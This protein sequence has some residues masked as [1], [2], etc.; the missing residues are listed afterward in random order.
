MSYL[1]AVRLHFAGTFRADVSTVNNYAPHFDDETFTSEE[2]L[3]GNDRGWWQ[4]AG[5]GA[6]RIEDC[7]V[8]RVCYLDGTDASDPAVEAAVGMKVME[9]N[10]R[11]SAKLVDLDV[12][13]QLVSTIYG[14]RIAVADPAGGKIL[15]SGEFEPAAFYDIFWRRALGGGGSDSGASA[16]YQ[17]V[18]RGVSWADVGHS[19][20]LTELR[21]RTADGLLSIRFMVDGYALNGPRRGY[22]RIVGT[23]GPAAADEPRHFV[24]GRHLCPPALEVNLSANTFGSV[25][26]AWSD[27]RNRFVADFGNAMPTSTPGGPAADI[28][29]VGLGI[30][31]PSGELLDLGVLNSG[32]EPWYERTAGIQ[33]FPPDREMTEEEIAVSQ[34]FPLVAFNYAVANGRLA[35]FQVKASEN[36]DGRF[37]RFDN[38]V[39][40][41][42]PG[43]SADML[44]WATR[45]GKPLPDAEIE[46][47]VSGHGLQPEG[48][49][50]TIPVADPAAAL[51]VSGARTDANGRAAVHLTAGNPLGKRKYID[52]QIYCVE[53]RIKNAAGTGTDFYPRSFGSVL[54]FD[55]P[56]YPD[57]VT[58]EKH[59]GPVFKQY[60]NLYPRPHGPDRY[61]PFSN[62]PPL[63]PVVN[64]SN[65]KDVVAFRHRIRRALS[66]PFDHPGYMPVVRDLS[67][68]KRDM[69]LRFFDQI[70]SGDDSSEAGEAAVV[71]HGVPEGSS[72]RGPAIDPNLGGKASAADRSRGSLFRAV[73]AADLV[74]RATTPVDK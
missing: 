73:K 26:V 10:D 72:E 54:V 50:P 17:S 63:R 41:L 66:L 15:V 3:P 40:R 12:M 55:A 8:T 35:R 14:L 56:D 47:A 60:S 59:A 39:Q 52:G 48:D 34:R 70:D 16:Y 57:R 36:P 69:I 20:A 68:A 1:N 42:D 21:Q 49:A 13:Q 4:P 9:A 27:E 31:V 43:E 23:I 67:K 62:T 71:L 64:L 46:T 25:T 74:A 58:W 18:L 44:A 51:T 38:L 30:A 45:F 32:A 37:V 61:E 65:Y 33:E 5:T 19:K 24:R 6:W 22:G 7:R 11:V 28:G 2:Q 53:I 29:F